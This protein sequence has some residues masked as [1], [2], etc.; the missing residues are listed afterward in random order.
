[1]G[2]QK[3]QLIERVL[4]RTENVATSE[5]SSHPPPPGVAIRGCNTFIEKTKLLRFHNPKSS[6]AEKTLMKDVYMCYIGVTEGKSFILKIR[7]HWLQ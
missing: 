5:Q 7:K 6:V 1:M 2:T 3:N 4:L